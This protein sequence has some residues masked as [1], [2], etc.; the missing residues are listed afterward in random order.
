[1]SDCSGWPN[2]RRD[3]GTVE[4][5][6]LKHLPSRKTLDEGK[7]GNNL[8]LRGI[9]ALWR[10]PGP[11]TWTGEWDSLPRSQLSAAFIP[12]QTDFLHILG[13][14]DWSKHR[15]GQSQCVIL[16]V[17]CPQCN[18]SNNSS[19]SMDERLSQ[20]ASCGREEEHLYEGTANAHLTANPH[21][22][23]FKAMLRYHLR[24]FIRFR[25]AP[26]GP[27]KAFDT[28][29]PA[30][31]HSQKRSPISCSQT[32]RCKNWSTGPLETHLATLAR[33]EG[34]DLNKPAQANQ[35]WNP[36]NALLI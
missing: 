12:K 6:N 9:K 1:M 23:H 2:T 21:I 27:T 34:P 22:F 8:F 20:A 29:S 14:F 31:W 4:N 10:E 17:H 26:A 16:I 35:K 28:T 7:S 13:S 30:P 25:T 19:S 33:S 15:P 5:G 32:W 3:I 11:D 36:I 24:Q 18:W